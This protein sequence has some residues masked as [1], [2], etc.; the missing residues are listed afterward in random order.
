MLVEAVLPS[1]ATVLI[2]GEPPSG[3]TDVSLSSALNL[4]ELR[5][6]MGEFADALVEPLRSMA[7]DE[8]ELEFSVG[9]ELGTGRMIAFFAA[10]KAQTGTKIRIL[11]KRSS[12][13]G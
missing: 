12:A 1:G 11:W 4:S 13:P 3:P 5:A 9:L 10:G 2:D 7:A 8:V 6:T